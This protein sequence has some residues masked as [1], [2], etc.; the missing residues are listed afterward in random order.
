MM[1]V[2]VAVVFVVSL[3]HS[4]K[5]ENLL[6]SY[7]NQRI[8][9]LSSWNWDLPPPSSSGSHQNTKYDPTRITRDASRAWTPNYPVRSLISNVTVRFSPVCDWPELF[10]DATGLSKGFNQTSE[11]PLANNTDISV[12]LLITYS[13]YEGLLKEGFKSIADSPKSSSPVPWI[14]S[15]KDGDGVSLD[16]KLYR[17]SATKEWW[18]H[19]IFADSAAR[20][21]T[22]QLEY[23]I[24]DVLVGEKETNTFAAPWLQEWDSPVQA[25]DIKW[26]FP[27][28]FKPKQFSIL[29]ENNK[30]DFEPSQLTAICCGNSDTAELGKCTYDRNTALKWAS[31]SNSVN[32]CLN[33]SVVFLTQ[34][35]LA[36]GLWA[37]QEAGVN[38]NNMYSV[39]FS[40]GLVRNG[41]GNVKEAKGY[42][43]IL[44]LVLILLFPC[45]GAVFWTLRS[46]Q[47]SYQKLNDHAA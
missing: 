29:P 6:D 37:D 35:R 44:P 43:W 31:Q 34:L 20:I 24:R 17:D 11:C 33:Q 25:M 2:S 15:V 27:S 5:S 36:T 7:E 41:A 4:T 40:P 14:K 18:I 13:A 8:Q 22:V 42:G 32:S 46:S 10:D 12:L 23:Q 38:L 30:A 45:L 16:Y 19:Y 3:L 26:V 9:S 28:N 21:C 1:R 39:T 47:D